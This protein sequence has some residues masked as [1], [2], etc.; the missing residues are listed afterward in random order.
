MEVKVDLE[1]TDGR[2][3]GNL[4]CYSELLWKIL[5]VLFNFSY[6]KKLHLYRLTDSAK[7]NVIHKLRNSYLTNPLIA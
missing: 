5:F 3:Y 4:R 2:K 7:Q 6:C 1:K